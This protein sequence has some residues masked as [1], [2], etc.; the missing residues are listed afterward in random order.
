[1]WSCL[2]IL[3][4][5]VCGLEVKGL[6]ASPTIRT[7]YGVGD[8]CRVEVQRSRAPHLRQPGVLL[9]LLMG[10]HPEFAECWFSALS[11]STVCMHSVIQHSISLLPRPRWV[12]EEA[13]ELG[14]TLPLGS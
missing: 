7:N 14:T 4:M 2:Q 8:Y 1:M 5:E 13:S 10:L 9:L 11:T 6:L 3:P 12:V